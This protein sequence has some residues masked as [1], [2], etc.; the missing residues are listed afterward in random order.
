LEFYSK[1]ILRWK[2]L[3][4]L[5]QALSYVVC[6]QSKRHVQNTNVEK[7]IRKKSQVVLFWK[8]KF[9]SCICSRSRTYYAL[10]LGCFD[11]KF[12]PD[13]SYFVY[14]VVTEI[15]ASNSLHKICNNFLFIIATTERN[16][17]FCLKLFDHCLTKYSSVWA[18]ICRVSSQILLGFFH[19]ITTIISFWKMVQKLLALN[20]APLSKYAKFRLSYFNFILSSYHAE[21]FW[22]H[23]QKYFYMSFL[24][25]GG[26][27]KKKTQSYVSSFVCSQSETY[28]TL[29]L[30]YIGIDQ[31][32]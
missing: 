28:Y 24:S 16:V 8:N 10:F 31:I 6:I 14:W 1:F 32:I 7:D 13:F 21:K 19:K 15:W 3:K 30:L 2:V 23:L 5:T 11:L 29:S 26:T 27:S 22:K 9:S 4:T 12:L 20:G 25:Q 17:R 18:E